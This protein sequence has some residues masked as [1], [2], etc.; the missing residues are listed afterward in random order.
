MSAASAV[1]IPIDI[2]SI[3]RPGLRRTLR[4][5]V[6]DTTSCY[7]WLPFDL[8]TAVG[9]RPIR[10]D[11]FE[12][13]GGGRL[14]DRQVGFGMIHVGDRSSVTA[15]VF[16]HADDSVFI[17]FHALSGLGLEVDSVRNVLVPSG[18]HPAATAGLRSVSAWHHAQSP[19][20]YESPSG[21]VSAEAD[22]HLASANGK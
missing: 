11:R 16:G 13:R 1:R 10:T 12:A 20:N 19:A 5:V 7:S 3:D 9:I 6:V 15:F 4:D 14:I 8:L 22:V 2:E 17:G 18:P 21:L